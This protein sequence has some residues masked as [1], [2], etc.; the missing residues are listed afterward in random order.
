MYTHV[1]RWTRTHTHTSR[2]GLSQ[3][4]GASLD[5][6]A[7]AAFRPLLSLPV[8]LWQASSSLRSRPSSVLSSADE[9]PCGNKFPYYC[10][11]SSTPPRLIFCMTC[12][13]SVS[14]SVPESDTIC[15][16]PPLQTLL[17]HHQGCQLPLSPCAP[18]PPSPWLKPQ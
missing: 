3:S 5:P 12:S 2:D 1:S 13:H 16:F 10:H 17:I 9:P 11:L 8:L 14:S 4:D 15:L 6:T 18:L 7:T